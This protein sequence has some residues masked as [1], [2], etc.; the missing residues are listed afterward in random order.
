MPVLGGAGLEWALPTPSLPVCLRLGY[1]AG[2]SGP[3]APFGFSGGVGV[4]WGG[5]RVDYAFCW[6]GGL[7]GSNRLGLSWSPGHAAGS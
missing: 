7:G 2:D 6:L 3:Q 4:N 5:L 1:A